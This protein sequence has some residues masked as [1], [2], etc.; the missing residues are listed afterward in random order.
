MSKKRKMKMLFFSRTLDFLDHY[1]PE[2]AMKSSNTIETYRDALTVF[3]RYI[4]DTLHMSIRSFC[5]EDCTHDFLLEYL[6]F[7]NASGNAATTCNNRLAAIRAYLWYVADGDI[8]FQSVALAA[9]HV[10]FL[11]VPKLTREIIEEDDL[12]ALLSAPANSKIGKRDRVILILL[13]DSAIRVSELLSLDVRSV[14]LDPAFPYIRIYGKGHKERIVAITDMT[15]KYFKEYIRIYHPEKEAD[16]PLIYTVIKGRRDQMSVGNIERIIKKYAE[17]IRPEHPNLPKSCYPHMV[18]RTRATNL[19]QD[20]TEL[21]LISRILGHTSTE[22]TRIYAIPSVEM[23]R[24]AMETRILSPNEEPQWPD[25]EAE[26]AR[27]CSL[28]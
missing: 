21:E 4:S 18:R 3:R 25:D 20:G 16:A 27:L 17:Q 23:M 5:F 15:S 19:Y 26:I 13:Y 8:T 7:L 11:K 2:Q 1:L 24:K 22:T 6:C 28:R 12:S 10:P 14:N 9:S